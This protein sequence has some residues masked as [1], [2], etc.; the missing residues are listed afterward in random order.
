MNRDMGLIE[1]NPDA[2]LHTDAKATS[3]GHFRDLHW[4][5]KQSTVRPLRFWNGG[6]VAS[7]TLAP[8]DSY[9]CF[10]SLQKTGLERN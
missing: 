10:G 5:T 8:A 6:I 2:S 9:F 7:P 1:E 3:K 4:R